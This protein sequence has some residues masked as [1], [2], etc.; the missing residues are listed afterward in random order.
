MAIDE[1]GLESQPWFVVEMAAD[2]PYQDV[3]ID[4][5]KTLDAQ[6]SLPSKLFRLCPGLCL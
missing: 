1:L 3:S 4:V 2:S 6:L 5:V